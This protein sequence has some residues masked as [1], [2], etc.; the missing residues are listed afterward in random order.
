MLD[1]LPYFIIP[2]L[3][4]VDIILYSIFNI[5]YS[6]F[7]ILYSLTAHSSLLHALFSLL[8]KIKPF[9]SCII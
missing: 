3:Q 2:A 1:Q 6:S 7:N 5:H 8:I 4:Q 9:L